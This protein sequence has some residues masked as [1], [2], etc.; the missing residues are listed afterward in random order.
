[1]GLLGLEVAGS[2][3][4]P[5]LADAVERAGFGSDVVLEPTLPISPLSL[6]LLTTTFCFCPWK[7]EG[8]TEA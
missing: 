5:V 6:G 3:A 1:M 2:P 8:K 4:R 7:Y